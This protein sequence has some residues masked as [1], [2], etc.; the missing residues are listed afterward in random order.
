METAR[1]GIIL[2]VEKFDECISFYKDLFGLK[3]LFEEQ[4]GEFKLTCF[5][6][7]GAYLMVET[8]GYAKPEGKSL[9][10]NSTKLRFNVSDIE[11]ALERITRYGIEAKIIR[12]DWGSTINIFD[13]DGNRVGVRDEV[14]FQSQIGT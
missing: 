3:V 11:G 2:N 10:E 12:N 8:D 7:G 4:Y 6:F 5:A 14:T 13:P 9:K 1:T